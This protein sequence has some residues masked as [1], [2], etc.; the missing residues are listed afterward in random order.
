MSTIFSQW[1]PE[2]VL[3]IG[4]VSSGVTCVGYVNS[5]SR[6]CRNMIAAVNR[7]RAT[8]IIHAMSRMDVSSPEVEESLEP[9]ARLLL[10]KRQ[11]RNQLPSVVEKWRNQIDGVQVQE[12]A[13]REVITEQEIIA[14]WEEV[15]RSGSV[16]FHQWTARLEQSV[17]DGDIADIQKT[18]K[19]LGLAQ[20]RERDFQAQLADLETLNA[21]LNREVDL[22]RTE[23]AHST[24][25][26]MHNGAPLVTS[27]ARAQQPLTDS[28][29]TVRHQISVEGD[30]QSLDGRS[31]NLSHR[32]RIQFELQSESVAA[33]QQPYPQIVSQPERS[34]FGLS[35]SL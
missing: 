14:E 19:L 30:Y 2:E 29:P 11:H 6:R 15:A 1:N 10:C 23:L 24:N 26:P 8:S 13:D 28:H 27:P 4:Q 20:K 16:A 18:L 12:A 17:L 32:I 3:E 34:F 33:S 25:D 7:K 22:L 21:D 9:L 5:Q 35:V 31:Q